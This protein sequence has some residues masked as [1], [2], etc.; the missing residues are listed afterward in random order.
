MSARNDGTEPT[1]ALHLDGLHA[2]DTDCDT[3]DP[4]K[5]TTFPYTISPPV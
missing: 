3:V 4:G 5:R 1:I 2:H